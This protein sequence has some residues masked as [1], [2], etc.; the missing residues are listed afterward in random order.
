MTNNGY[1]VIVD[2]SGEQEWMQKLL[3]GTAATGLVR[4]EWVAAR[5]GQ[6]SPVNWS[7]MQYNEIIPGYYPLRYLVA[8][9]QNLIVQA[10]IERGFEWLLLWEHDVIPQ[11]DALIRIN[12]Y[13]GE[14]KI[15][16]V[17]GLYHNRNRPSD[18]LI[19]RGRGTGA[20]KDFRKGDLVWCDGV[21]TGFLLIHM[22]IL[23]L[24]YA[25]AELYTVKERKVRRVFITPR[26]FELFEGG[27]VST[28]TGTSD[29]DWCTRVMEGD[30]FAKA[31]WPEFAEKRYP[32]LVDTNIFCMH[33]NPNGE[34]FP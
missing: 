5:Y 8:D 11:P 26:K 29:L 34:Q 1:S 14:H 28:V 27:D 32:F 25:D 17:S 31:G 16:V 23:K 21:P 18:P 30:Y 15:P 9:A 22:S 19:F 3:I 24:M 6:I 7:Q 33:I 12:D 4:L 2:D 20:F 10:A 13:M